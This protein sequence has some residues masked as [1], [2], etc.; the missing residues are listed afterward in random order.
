MVSSPDVHEF[1]I[2][3]QSDLS[4]QFFGTQTPF[5]NETSAKHFVSIVFPNF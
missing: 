3:G 5:P 1:P 2:L 4:W